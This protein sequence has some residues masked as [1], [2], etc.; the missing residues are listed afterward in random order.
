M[1]KIKRTANI[2]GKSLYITAVGALGFSRVPAW[3]APSSHQWL[4]LHARN[5]PPRAIFSTR[6][7][8]APG[9]FWRC[10]ETFSVVPIG[11][12]MLLASSGCRPGLLLIS[13]RGRG[14]D[15]DKT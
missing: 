15:H 5:L 13:Y 2:K 9:D 6:G 12:V 8:Q 7:A 11:A 14:T 1:A 3:P 10:L 4:S